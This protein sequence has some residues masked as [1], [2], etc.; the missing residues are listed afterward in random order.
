MAAE[1][2]L[3]TAPHGITR[4]SFRRAFARAM[5][6]TA[7]PLALVAEQIGSAIYD[8]KLDLV[9]WNPGRMKVRSGMQGGSRTI[10]ELKRALKLD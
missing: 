9:Q 6:Y 10:P 5:L 1:T 2:G 4:R 7:H 3:R 8:P